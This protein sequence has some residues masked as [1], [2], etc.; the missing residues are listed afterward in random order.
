MNRTRRQ[1][2]FWLFVIAACIV[3]FVLQKENPQKTSSY[4][5]N[6]Y[7]RGG[8]NRLFKETKDSSPTGTIAKP[9]RQQAAS[10]EAQGKG[11]YFVPL[12]SFESVDLATKRYLQV[13]RAVP[14]LEKTDKIAIQTIKVTDGTRHRVKMG[15]FAS[16]QLAQSACVKAGIVRAECPVVAVR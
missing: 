13:A 6:G 1:E 14:G 16:V 15:D 7:D 8:M 10:K 5:Q 2:F 11:R 4:D 3:L 12:G 9:Y